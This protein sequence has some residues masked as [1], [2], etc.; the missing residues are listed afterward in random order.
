M[1]PNLSKDASADS[2]NNITDG[3]SGSR[4]AMGEEN[5]ESRGAG[6]VPDCPDTADLEASDSD[7]KPERRN[8]SEVR[9][10]LKAGNLCDS[11]NTTVSLPTKDMSLLLSTRLSPSPVTSSHIMLLTCSIPFSSS[12]RK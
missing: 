5:E 2:I 11:T 3:A 4:F 1:A 10:E 12:P 8:S 9:K 6:A 7:R